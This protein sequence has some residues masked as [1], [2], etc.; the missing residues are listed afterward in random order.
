[1]FFNNAVIFIVII[2][3]YT[4]TAYSNSEQYENKVKRESPLVFAL[5]WRLHAYYLRKR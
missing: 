1:M 4:S 3:E 5:E 2:S